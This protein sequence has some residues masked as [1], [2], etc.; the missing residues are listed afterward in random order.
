MQLHSRTPRDPRL[1]GLVR[2]LWHCRAPDAR[3]QERMLPSGTMQLIVNLNSDALRHA[4]LIGGEVAVRSG[5]VIQ[6]MHTR[7]VVLDRADQRDVLGVVFEPG[8]GRVLLGTP[9]DVLAHTHVDLFELT[10]G[11][12]PL[13]EQLVGASPEDCFDRTERWLRARIQGEVDRTIHAALGLM[14]RGEQRVAVLASEVGTSERSLRRRFR[15][16]VGLPPKQMS[17][18]LRLQRALEGLCGT[19]PLADVAHSSG[20][21]DQAHFTHELKELARISP[22]EYRRRRL[23]SHRSHLR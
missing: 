3:G 12:A 11:E 19:S 6:G 2:S 17:R 16:E 9:L 5:A 21:H 7:A 18:V 22:S 23:L 15:A 1:C 14:Q 10:R 8:A 4:D 20:Y 13:R